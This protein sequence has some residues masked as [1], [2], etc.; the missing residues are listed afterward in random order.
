MSVLLAM[1]LV[2]WIVLEVR[3][4]LSILPFR[5]VLGVEIHFCNWFHYSKLVAKQKN[6]IVFSSG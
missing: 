3:S 6:S 5:F 1:T 4:C 2:R